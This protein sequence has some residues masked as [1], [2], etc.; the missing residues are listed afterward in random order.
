MVLGSVQFFRSASS[1]VKRTTLRGAAYAPCE[2]SL[3]GG[4]EDVGGPYES[5]H[6][7]DDEELLAEWRRIERGERSPASRGGAAPPRPAGERSP[8]AVVEHEK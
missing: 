6:E 5:L 8:Q 1:D 3:D 2:E 7:L 4:R